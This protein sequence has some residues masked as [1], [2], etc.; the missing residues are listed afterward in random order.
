MVG[1]CEMLE[2]CS[3]FKRLFEHWLITCVVC[4]LNSDNLVLIPTFLFLHTN[5]KATDQST[6]QKST[7][8]L[9]FSSN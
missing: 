7:M 2:T 3:R 5:C 1:F 9:L 6:L 4:S 8:P